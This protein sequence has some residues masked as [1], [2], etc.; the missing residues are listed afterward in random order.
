KQ[1]SQATIILRLA[2]DAELFHTADGEAYATI[3][4]DN[5]RETWQLRTRAFK[6]WLA[7]LFYAAIE[8]SP[9]A[10]AINDALGVLEGKALFDGPEL[11]VYVRVAS[12]N[13]VVYV[14]LGNERWEAVEV[15]ASGWKVVSD[16]PVRFRRARGMAAL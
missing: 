3:V 8:K 10:Q 5:H 13:D 14:D 6:R 4:V 12:L 1:P 16:P 2:K 9:S 11:P 15:A 7:R